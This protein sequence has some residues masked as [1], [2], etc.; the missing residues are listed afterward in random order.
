MVR[1][2]G[3]L[4][5][6]VC[7]ITSP[8]DGRL[9]AEAGADAVGFVFWPMSPRRTRVDR[10]ADIARELPPFVLRVGVFVNAT[11]DEMARAADE[12]GLDLLQLHGEEPPEALLDLPRRCLKAVRVGAGFA[13]EDALRYVGAASG[14]LVDTRLAGETA[15]PGGTG[16]PFDW[17]LVRD[18]RE[19]VPFLMLAG[20]LNADNVEAAVT[21]VGPDAVDVSSGVE[22]LPGRKDA[23]RLRAFIDAVRRAERAREAAG[24][25]GGEP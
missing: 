19:R 25:G 3:R 22:T 9:A 14:V 1:R 7:G 12:V 2:S 18:L 15:M 23:V 16:T 20:G 4:L 24:G 11:R 17:R 13:A 21:A 8:E 5:V 10:A 6:K